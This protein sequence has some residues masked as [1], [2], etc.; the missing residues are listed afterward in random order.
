MHA[1]RPIKLQGRLRRTSV[2]YSLHISH[3]FLKNHI[4]WSGDPGGGED[5]LQ[6][7]VT[8]RRTSVSGQP[9]TTKVLSEGTGYS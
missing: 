1:S 9:P 3:F 2:T 8:P 4:P 6:I 7:T 5:E